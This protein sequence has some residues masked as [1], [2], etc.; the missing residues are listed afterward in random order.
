MKFDYWRVMVLSSGLCGEMVGLEAGMSKF[1][2]F[3]SSTACFLR[4]F[5]P[6]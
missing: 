4:S 6:L 2:K 3:F 1:L 5:V